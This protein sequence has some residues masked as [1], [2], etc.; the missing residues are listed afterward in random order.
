MNMR[1]FAENYIHILNHT[2]FCYNVKGASHVGSLS[3]D[4]W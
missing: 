2:V 4:E 1:K 3:F